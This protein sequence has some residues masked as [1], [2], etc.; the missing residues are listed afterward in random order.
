[1][2]DI[3]ENKRLQMEWKIIEAMELEIKQAGKLSDETMQCLQ[4]LSNR[5]PDLLVRI[6]EL[7]RKNG[8]YH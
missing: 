5:R 7:W 2:Q 8:Q 3:D 4:D 6:N 1:M